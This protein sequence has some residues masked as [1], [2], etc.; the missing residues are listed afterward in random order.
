MGIS[1][2]GTGSRIDFSNLS[3]ITSTSYWNSSLSVAN[4]GTVVAPLLATLSRV[5]L[6]TSDTG[7]L[8][9]AQIT[10]FSGGSISASS[11]NPDYSGLSTLENVNLYAWNGARIAFPNLTSYTTTYGTT[12]QA[13]GTAT[14]GTPSTIDLS[15]LTSLPGPSDYYVVHPEFACASFAICTHESRYFLIIQPV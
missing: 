15:G 14:D 6:T 5:D 1:A 10:S 12:I 4:G 13:Y 7:T 9:T 2:T 8:N 3:A 11:T